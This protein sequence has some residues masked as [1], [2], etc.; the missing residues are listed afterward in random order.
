MFVANS[1]GSLSY[2]LAGNMIKNSL[3]IQQEWIIPVLGFLSLV[4]IV[5]AIGIWNWKKWGI[6]G[7]YIVALIAFVIN[8]S[9]GVSVVR[10]LFGLALPVVLFFLI[11]P[12]W[13]HY[14]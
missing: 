6:Y 3:K 10:S 2:L 14:S 7:V 1:I 4:N 5:F 11:R 9:L 12:L 8:I 13:E